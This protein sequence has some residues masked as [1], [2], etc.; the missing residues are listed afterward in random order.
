[1]SKSNLAAPNLAAP[2]IKRT[3]DDTVYVPLPN[4][5][6]TPAAPAGSVKAPNAA[7][8]PADDEARAAFESLKAQ[9]KAARPE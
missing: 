5:S 4:K 2:N 1:L 3:D 6:N 9:I 8:G 7:G